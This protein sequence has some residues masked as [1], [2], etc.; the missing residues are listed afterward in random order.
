MTLDQRIEED[1]KELYNAGSMNG[2]ITAADALNKAS[3][4]KDT[5]SIQ[6]L[7]GHFVGKREADTVFVALN[8]GVDAKTANSALNDDIR[9]LKISIKSLDD[10]I[11]TY[12]EGRRNFGDFDYSRYHRFDLK[13]ALF[14][15]PWA[16]SGI[17]FSSGFPS[18]N[19]RA[20]SEERL[21]AKRD[22]LM[23]KLQLELL[24]FCSAKF[25]LTGKNK[26]LLY[27]YVETLLGEIFRKERKYIIFAG[28]SFEE[29]FNDESEMAKI[30]VSVKEVCTPPPTSLTKKDGS[31]SKTLF[32]CKKIAITYKGKTQ[33]A[34]IAHTYPV[35]FGGTIFYQYGKFCYETYKSS[36]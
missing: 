14:L 18:K 32:R 12:K 27:P 3:V 31:P 6:G 4:I 21:D 33:E 24:P 8:P 29:L 19:V 9:K 10:F 25:K 36:I 15:A 17:H 34:M 11:D 28:S 13:Q 35:Q 2:T 7:P 23:Q 16:N 22:V 20:K 26:H 5:L 30:G 1:L